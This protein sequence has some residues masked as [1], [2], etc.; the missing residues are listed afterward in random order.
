MGGRE[1][2][3]VMIWRR[4][5]I[6]YAQPLGFCVLCFR[7]EICTGTEREGGKE[8]EGVSRSDGGKY[9]RERKVME[10]LFSRFCSSFF[11]FFFLLLLDVKYQLIATYIV[12]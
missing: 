8:R 5:C 7:G 9:E 2:G 1:C 11:F 3:G 12:C 6:S 4:R 10:G